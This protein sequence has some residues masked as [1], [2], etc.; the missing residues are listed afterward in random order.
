MI[1]LDIFESVPLNYMKNKNNMQINEIGWGHRR[2]FMFD[3][4]MVQNSQ[5]YTTKM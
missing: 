3:V 1:D 4:R 2:L 5:Y